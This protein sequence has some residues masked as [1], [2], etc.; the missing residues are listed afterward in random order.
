MAIWY[1]T[2]GDGDFS[3]TTSW[4]SLPDG[5]GSAPTAFLDGSNA[6]GEVQDDDTLVF[7]GG[8]QSVTTNTTGFS[9]RYVDIVGSA[10]FYGAVA[11]DSTGLD[12]GIGQMRWAGSGPVAHF[13]GG[14]DASATSA[15]AIYVDGT[16]PNAG[17]L[18]LSGDWSTAPG[19]V[20]V[21]AGRVKLLADF[22][23][24]FLRVYGGYV[25]DE[26]GT[27]IQDV[28]L[29]GG[30]YD[31]QNTP[32][33]PGGGNAYVNLYSGKYTAR[34]SSN[35]T[36]YQFGGEFDYRGSADIV[37]AL[38]VDGKMLT[39]RNPYS[40]AFGTS[41]GSVQKFRRHLL[42]LR[43]PGSGLISF[44]GSSAGSFVR[45]GAGDP[46]GAPDILYFPQSLTGLTV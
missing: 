15:N 23:S 5:S 4:N 20:E 8:S 24:D 27:Q 3:A 21:N 19:A 10:E 22:E 29:D 37:A 34:G 7:A 11:T 26:V 16:G 42:D 33:D 14:F 9:S 1:W 41:D 25:E 43:G 17:S 35:F 38:L 13:A 46:S 18:T 36:M 30:E 40:F 6:A 12:V 31:S 28:Y 44:A 39:V 32:D 45:R 2:S